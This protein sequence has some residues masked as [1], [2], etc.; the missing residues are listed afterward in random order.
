V[1]AEHIRQAVMSR[2]LV[3]WST[4][5]TIGHVTLSAGIAAYRSGDT[6]QSLIER[7]DACLYGA[8]RAGRNR[9]MPESGLRDIA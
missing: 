3:K 9:V 1:V 6:P 7:T 2:N 8:K 4:G 5:E